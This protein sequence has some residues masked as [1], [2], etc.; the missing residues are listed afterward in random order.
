L[1]DSEIDQDAK[2]RNQSKEILNLTSK[3]AKAKKTANTKVN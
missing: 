3:K 2:T 1:K